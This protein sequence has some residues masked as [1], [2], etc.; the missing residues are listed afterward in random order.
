MQILIRDTLRQ[1]IQDLLVFACHHA[2]VPKRGKIKSPSIP[3]KKEKIQAS[4]SLV[5]TLG[6]QLYYR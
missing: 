6:Q 5:E 1:R 3:E 2:F 4:A